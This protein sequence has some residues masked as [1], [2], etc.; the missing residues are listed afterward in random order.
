MDLASS[1]SISISVTGAGNYVYELD[2][3]DGTY[4]E[5]SVFTNV[6]AG[7]HTIYVKDLYGYGVVTKEVAN[8]IT[9]YC[10]I[11]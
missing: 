7:I 10:S 4:Q 5:D 6:S 3:E 9:A 2:D 1:N 11:R 8:F